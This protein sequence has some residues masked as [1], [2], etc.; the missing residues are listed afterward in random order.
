MM[1]A[2][3]PAVMIAHGE[4]LDAL[5]AEDMAALAAVADVLDP[6]PVHHWGDPRA[7]RLLARAEVLLAHWGCPRL[8]AAVLDAAPALRLVAYAGGSVRPL[9]STA[10]F[11]RGIVVTSAAAANAL[12]VAEYTLAAILF[13]NKQVLWS[14]RSALP[15]GNAGKTV[16]LVGAGHVGR[17]VASLLRPFPDLAV[18]VSDPHLPSAD[19]AALGARVVPLGE[20]CA[21]AHIVSLHV[22]ALATTRHLL[23]R[24]ELA[25]MR[26]GGTLINTARGSVVDH[27]ALLDELRAGRLFAVLDVTDPEP[28]PAD[29]PMRALPNVW[30]TP[31]RSG[32]EGTE[33]R[34]LAASVIDEVRRYALGEAPLHLVT[35]ASLETTA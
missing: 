14:A 6:R 31:H 19:A 1:R 33:L 5:A 25:A 4:G 28:L 15:P 32:S 26:D 34:R 3:R 7:R 22:P 35:A 11:D 2:E 21:V 23:G 27:D 10:A 20:L 13:A 17:R 18:V 24:R 9:V 8:D 30:L 29:H 16:G 12:A